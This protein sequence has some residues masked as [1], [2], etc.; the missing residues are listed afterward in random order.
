MDEQNLNRTFARYM[1]LNILGMLGMSGY[2]LA[3][4]FFVSS[5]LGSDGL[6]ALNLA[7]SVFGFINGLGMM[8]GIGGATRYAICKARED[9]READGSFTLP[10]WRARTGLVLV[11]FGRPFSGR[12]LAGLWARR[13][14]SPHVHGVSAHR[15]PLRPLLHPQPHPDGLCPQRRQPQAGHDRHAGG[16]PVQHRAGLPV[17]LPPEYGAFSAPPWPPAPPPS[18]A[19]LSP[20]S[21][22]SPA[23]ASSRLC[24]PG[25]PCGRWPLWP[26]WAS[27]PLSMSSP[28]A[29]PWWC[30]TC[31]SWTTAGTTGVA[32]Y[33]I[34][35]NLALV[36]LAV[37][38]G[39]AQ[40][41]QPLLS[42][43]YGWGTGRG[44]PGAPC[45]GAGPLRRGGAGRSGRRP[46]GRPH[47]LVSL[48]NSE[49][50]PPSRPGGSPA[51][52]STSWASSSWA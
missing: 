34:V 19:S 4:T 51:C 25:C 28:P 49:G 11:L 3:D 27:P 42:R 21:T 10:W 15:L 23:A 37:F 46:A 13:I 12:G 16:Q 29:S 24:P 9:D 39:M 33:G 5:R 7:I 41:I 31:W 50:D 18:S 26:V 47:A 6:A 44:R 14:H 17:R 43:A 8:L 45:A 48:F 38:T 36:V 40:G 30:S 2:I 32:A 52:G 22:F 20:P 1:S 35:A